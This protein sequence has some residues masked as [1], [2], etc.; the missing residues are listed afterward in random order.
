MGATA[1]AAAAWDWVR[2]VGG[3]HAGRVVGGGHAGRVVG[4]K[5][6]GRE[7]R[8][9]CPTPPTPP[10]AT[11]LGQYGC[12]WGEGQHEELRPGRQH[13]VRHPEGGGPRA[14]QGGGGEGS[15]RWQARRQASRS[16]MVLGRREHEATTHGAP[17]ARPPALLPTLLPTP[18]PS[19][20]ACGLAAAV[21]TRAATKS[22]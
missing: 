5:R 13:S 9:L 8:C 15:V 7:P 17:S 1:S 2:F 20:R 19:G 21:A 4:E 16:L 10:P 18:Q 22:A 3:G 14:G 12:A 11:H 6:A